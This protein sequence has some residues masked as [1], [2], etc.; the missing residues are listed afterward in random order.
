MA[1]LSILRPL[2]ESDLH[3]LRTDPVG[4]HTRQAYGFGEW[5]FWD[6]KFV[7]LGAEIEEKLSVEAGADLSGIGEI[8]GCVRRPTRYRRW[9]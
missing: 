7:E 9:Y 2:N 1:E 3:D 8:G 5:W 4:A 6:L